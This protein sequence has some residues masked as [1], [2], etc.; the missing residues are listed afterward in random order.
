M[1]LEGELPPASTAEEALFSDLRSPVFSL[2]LSCVV[3]CPRSGCPR[4][5]PFGVQGSPCLGA[6]VHSCDAPPAPAGG[7]VLMLWAGC[8]PTALVSGLHP[9]RV[10]TLGSVTTSPSSHP[11]GQDVASLGF[12]EHIRETLP[13]PL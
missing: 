7:V 4:R 10:S 3:L 13:C 2:F 12:V 11:L 8:S 6:S 5:M 1:Y 9:H